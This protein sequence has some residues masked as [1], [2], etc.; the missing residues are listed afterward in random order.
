MN[1][2]DRYRRWRSPAQWY[3]DHPAERKQRAEPNKNAMGSWLGSRGRVKKSDIGPS[4]RTD[5]ERDFK[6]PRDY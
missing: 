5:F 3:D 2:R 4:G 6:K 1:L